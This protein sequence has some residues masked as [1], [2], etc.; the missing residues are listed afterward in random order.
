[1]HFDEILESADEAFSEYLRLEGEAYFGKGVFHL[2]NGGY[3]FILMLKLAEGHVRGVV[4]DKG[5]GSRIEGVMTDRELR[6]VKTYT[7][8]HRGINFNYHRVGDSDKWS[9]EFQGQGLQ[10]VG[11]TNCVI[12]PK[13][14]GDKRLIALMGVEG[15]SEIINESPLGEMIDNRRLFK[16]N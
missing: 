8:N 13:I 16:L 1:M 2:R 6:F 9:G 7:Y 12:T 14:G 15:I 5:G 3:P 11:K 10:Y 4:A